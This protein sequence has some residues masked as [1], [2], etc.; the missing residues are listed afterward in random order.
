MCDK[1]VIFSSQIATHLR[2]RKVIKIIN[3]YAFQ[4]FKNNSGTDNIA[5]NCHTYLSMHVQYSYCMGDQRL[6]ET[7]IKRHVFI[8]KQI[9]LSHIT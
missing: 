5:N 3:K 9:S 8:L 4:E 7:G 1:I 2:K 6:I